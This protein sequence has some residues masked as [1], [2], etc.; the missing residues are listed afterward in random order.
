MEGAA[1]RDGPALAADWHHSG[2]AIIPTLE[3]N[4][5]RTINAIRITA[6]ADCSRLVERGPS[7]QATLGIVCRRIPS[8]R[9]PVCEDPYL[10]GRSIKR[11]DKV[12][13]RRAGMLRVSSFVS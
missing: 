10:N 1:V 3:C 7:I 2:A 12:R 4:C 11:Y 5:N 8:T 13:A 6:W 9:Q